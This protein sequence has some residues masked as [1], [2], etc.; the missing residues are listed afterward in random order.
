LIAGLLERDGD[1][2]Y[3][4]AIVLNPQGELLAKYHKQ[5]LEH[6][7]VRITPGTDSSVVDTPFG[8]LDVMICADRRNEKV[9]RQF[10]SRGAELLICPSG[11]MFGPKKNDDILRRR[12]REN[13]KYIIF[14]HPAE[15]LVTSPVG[16]IA[17]RVL[18]G[19]ELDM[20]D[21][22]VDTA[23]DSRGV[24]FFD[25]QRSGGHWRASAVSHSLS[26]PLL[27]SGQSKEELR[28]YVT[29][30]IPSVETPGSKAEWLEEA[31]RLREQVLRKVVFQGA[32]CRDQGRVVRHD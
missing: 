32:R 19:D 20:N 13:G 31:A 29:A 27:T 1:R 2:L 10:C 16:D 9:V 21:D 5:M 22:E 28:T 3:N 6:E 14:T 11:G 8:K 15:F 23:E 25:L 26:Q 18:L 30:R 7:A 12:S 17:Q 4:T 24:F